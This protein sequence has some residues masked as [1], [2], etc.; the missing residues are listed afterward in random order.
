MNNSCVYPYL[1]NYSSLH[2]IL[3]VCKLLDKTNVVQVNTFLLTN[4]LTSNKYNLHLNVAIERIVSRYSHFYKY[5]N[6][7][8][9]VKTVA[10]M[11][12]HIHILM[13]GKHVPKIIST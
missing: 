7:H 6:L 5:L 2:L 12:T 4:I 10:K 8:V 11:I 1:Y 3:M 13:V 9:N